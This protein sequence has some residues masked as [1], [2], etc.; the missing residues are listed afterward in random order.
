MSH[1]RT[2]QPIKKNKYDWGKIVNK[3]THLY[4]F[5]LK[6]VQMVSGKTSKRNWKILKKCGHRKQSLFHALFKFLNDR[7]GA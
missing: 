6:S 1:P 5:L 3:K 2:N 7:I 4:K